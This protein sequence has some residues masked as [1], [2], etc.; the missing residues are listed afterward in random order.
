MFLHFRA[1]LFSFFRN[2]QKQKYGH[3][4]QPTGK[5]R[6]TPT[7]HG[8]GQHSWCQV[9][10]RIKLT[11]LDGNNKSR[12]FPEGFD[13]HCGSALSHNNGNKKQVFWDLDVGSPEYCL[14]LNLDWSCSVNFDSYNLE[15][16]LRQTQVKQL[17]VETDSYNYSRLR[18]VQSFFRFTNSLIRVLFLSKFFIHRRPLLVSV[19]KSVT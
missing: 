17:P 8:S 2:K 13:G 6:Y 15:D 3:Q 19:C 14:V 5:F 10:Q 11:F 18:M 7:V 4:R 1:Y 12:R 9:F 16:L